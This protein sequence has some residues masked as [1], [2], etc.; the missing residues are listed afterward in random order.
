MK[1]TVHAYIGSAWYEH[2]DPFMGIAIRTE[3]RHGKNVRTANSKLESVAMATAR[4]SWRGC[5]S[6]MTWSAWQETVCLSGCLLES[7]ELT[8]EQLEDFNGTQG[9]CYLETY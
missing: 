6:G 8:D 7:V 5:D 4:D 3:S 2:C 9:F 1:T